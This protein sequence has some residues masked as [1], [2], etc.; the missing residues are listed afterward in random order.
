MKW[1]RRT[2]LALRNEFRGQRY[3]YVQVMHFERL[4]AIPS[5]R[6]IEITLIWEEKWITKRWQR[7]FCV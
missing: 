4:A 3:L 5:S 1:L 7:A 2:F 6:G